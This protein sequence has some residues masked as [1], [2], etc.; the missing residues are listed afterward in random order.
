MPKLIAMK[1][2]RVDSLE[3]VVFTS[4]RE[5]TACPHGFNTRT[6]VVAVV[7]MVETASALGGLKSSLQ[8]NPFS[9]ID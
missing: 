1:T 8:A 6:A 2:D 7:E 3:Q 9:S 4:L 5:W